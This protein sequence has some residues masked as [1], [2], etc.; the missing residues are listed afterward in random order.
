MKDEFVVLE[1]FAESVQNN[2][3]NF[4]NMI[5]NSVASNKSNYLNVAFIYS[6]CKYPSLDFDLQH[7]I[8]KILK[9]QKNVELRFRNNQIDFINATIINE[10]VPSDE[11]D[12]YFERLEALEDKYFET[13]RQINE[14]KKIFESFEHRSLLPNVIINKEKLFSFT[15]GRPLVI[16]SE[17]WAEYCFNI[18]SQCFPEFSYNKHLS[19]A[20]FV[21]FSKIID[22]NTMIAL[23]YDNKRIKKATRSHIIEVPD[24]DVVLVF[25]E[26]VAK[27][28]VGNYQIINLGSADSW[29]FMPF[30]TRPERYLA[31]KITRKIDRNTSEIDSFE[32][33]ETV[34]EENIK[35]S[36]D[37]PY[38]ED[39]KFY[40]YFYFDVYSYCSRIYL[41][42]IESCINDALQ[43]PR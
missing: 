40:L 20:G 11:W 35:V 10:G 4:F 28:K 41:N 37:F 27:S 5:I 9:I 25:G 39:M 34:D 17:N 32:K 26:M 3:D 16:I 38:E 15:H 22:N 24:L 43:H 8:D 18:I 19:K 6:L 12:R 31:K 29:L 21:L 13:F 42:F 23:Q 7:A 14:K 30:I 2:L 36:F 1:K 33:I